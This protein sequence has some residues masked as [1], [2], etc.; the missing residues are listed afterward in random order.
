MGSLMRSIDGPNK[1][2]K[3]MIHMQ[4]LGQDKASFQ[5]FIESVHQTTPEQLMTLAEKYFVPR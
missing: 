1:I 2:L 4:V 3:R 5:R